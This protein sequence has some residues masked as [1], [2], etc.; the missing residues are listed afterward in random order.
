MTIFAICQTSFG[1]DIIDNQTK[2]RTLAQDAKKAGADI[3]VFCEL[4]LAGV[5]PN[6]LFLQDD[7]CQTVRDS[8]P[9]GIDDIIV[10][11]GYIHQDANGRYNAVSIIQNQA[12]GFYVKQRGDEIFEAGRNQVLF[13]HKGL[14][15]GLCFYDELEEI[16]KLKNQ[17]AQVV[18]VLGKDPFEIGA[19]QA[20]KDKLSAIAQKTGVGVLFANALGGFDSRVYDGGSMAIQPTGEIAHEASRFLPAVVLAK[21]DGT[22]FDGHKKAPLNLSPES[23]MYHALVVGLRDY[24]ARSGF[25]GAIIGLSGGIDSALTLCIAVDALG[26]DNVYAVQMPYEYTSKMSLEDAE[27]QAKRLGVS[28]TVCPINDA[29]AGFERMLAPILKTAPSVVKENLQARARGTT[30]MALS[31]QFGHLVLSTGNKSELAVGYC[32]LY[33]DMVGGFSVLKDVYKTDVYRLANY[34]NRLED[35][36]VIP[37][38]VIA[39]P[40]SAELAEGQ[41]DQDT[42]P[43]YD[44]LDAIL[45]AYVDEGKSLAQIVALDFDEAL[46]Q[47]VIRMTDKAEHKRQQGATGIKITSTPFAERTMPIINQYTQKSAQTDNTSKIKPNDDAKGETQSQQQN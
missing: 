1:T 5:E 23:Q 13:E 45:R 34:R 42:L 40:P 8:L 17:G 47:K 27:A 24:V 32:T 38:R 37:E 12:R 9:T 15:I 14:S 10:L 26:K 31:N 35:E 29:V 19:H 43:D 33:G 3:V 22:Q 6:A 36:P 25:N 30:L 20:R 2:I 11:A 4:A 39:R 16:E 18:I 7:F 44:T 41:T 28:Y 21:F 46:V